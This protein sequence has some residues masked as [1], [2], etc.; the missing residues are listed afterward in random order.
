MQ[1]GALL[2]EYSQGYSDRPFAAIAGVVHDPAI[3]HHLT[4]T[5]PIE[6]H[7]PVGTQADKI[8]GELIQGES[9]AVVAAA[10][11]HHNEYGAIFFDSHAGPSA[12]SEAISSSSLVTATWPSRTS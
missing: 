1:E 4:G 8:P 10:I 5:A 6:V 9:G 3:H 12:I 7:G 2:P 11:G